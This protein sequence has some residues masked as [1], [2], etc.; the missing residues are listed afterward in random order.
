MMQVEENLDVTY[1]DVGRLEELI[2]LIVEVVELPMVHPEAFEQLGIDPP[3]SAL[4]YGPPVTGKTQIARAVSNRT[5][6]A[7]IRVIGS[8]LVQ[9]YIGEGAKMERDAFDMAKR[10]I[11]VIFCGEVDAIRGARFEDTTGENEVQLST[12][13]LINQLDGFDKRR[14]IKM[15]MATNRPDTLS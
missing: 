1:K 4:L 7:F 11:C 3:K 6:S 14:K 5:D 9:K 10:K 8:G 2:Q 12:L 13:E 15:L